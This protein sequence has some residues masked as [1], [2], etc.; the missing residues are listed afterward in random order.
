M[1]TSLTG[2]IVPSLKS[3]QVLPVWHPVVENIYIYLVSLPYTV[4]KLIMMHSKHFATP[5]ES[6][7]YQ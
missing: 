6:L 7:H 3:F 4:E 1:Q 5:T 2:K